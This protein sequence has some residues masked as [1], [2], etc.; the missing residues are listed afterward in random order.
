[1]REQ[2]TFEWNEECEKAFNWVKFELTSPRVLAH[3]DPSQKIILACD[4]S[5]YG[6]SAVLSHKYEDGTEK[7]IAY[8]S[9]K[10]P[11]KEI[12]RAIIDKEASAI[13]FGFKRFY[14]FVYGREIILRTDHKPLQHIFGS[15][16]GIPI[17]AAS[18]LQ[19]WAYFLSG[20]K[21][22]IE[23]VKSK[24]NGNCD[25]LSRLPIEDEYSNF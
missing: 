10:I 5:A 20:Y 21:Y 13:V 17:T 12:N 14:D 22:T 9:K 8:A 1:M 24:D 23:Y 2:K 16:K 18:R 4:A 7:P 19:R 3:F 6:L 11:A 15:K 25:A